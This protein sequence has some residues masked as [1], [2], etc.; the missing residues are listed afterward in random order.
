M[1]LAHPSP[2][3]RARPS[4]LIARMGDGWSA[5]RSAQTP[6]AAP[7]ESTTRR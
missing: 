7:I 6:P 2:T 5:Q 1:P 3:Q 4:D